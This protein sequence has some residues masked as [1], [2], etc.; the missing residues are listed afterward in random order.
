[1]QQVTVRAPASTSNLGPGFD[2]LGLALRLYNHVTV[3][4]G[5]G[6]PVGAMAGSAGDAFFKRAGARAFA[7]SCSIAGEIPHSR[8]LGSSA[9]LRLGLLHGLNELA[10]RPLERREIFEICAGLEGHPDNAAPGCYGGFNVV[11]GLDRQMFTV[12]AQLHFVLLVPDFEIA[13]AEARR[14]L[15]SRVDRLQAVENSRN[16]CAI[17]A[18]FASR[19]YHSLRGAFADHLHQPFR[20]KLIPFLDKVIAA[21]E[22]AGA[23]G[24]FLSGSGSTVCAITLRSPEK[25]AGAMLAAANS[26]GARV[27]ITIADNRGARLLQIENRKS[28]IDN[29]SHEPAH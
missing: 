29:S 11:R 19:E 14:L 8:G 20:K 17:T 13:T 6:E 5:R 15:P 9:A 7:F 25:V 16:A 12:S 2:C 3:S 22:S 18:A 4:R 10:D 28:K 1:M 27:L 21:A 26:P 23:L 24:A